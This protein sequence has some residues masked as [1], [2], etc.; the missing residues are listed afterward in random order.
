M[1]DVRNEVRKPDER[2]TLVGAGCRRHVPH[3]AAPGRFERLRGLPIASGA[4]LM[5][6]VLACALA[7]VL[8]NCDPKAFYYDALNVPPNAEHYFGT[9]ALGRDLFSIMLYG[10]R[11]SLGIGVLAAAI[12]AAIGIIYGSVSGTAGDRIDSAMMRLAELLGSIPSLLIVLILTAI[13]PAKNVFSMSAVIGVTGWLGLAR[14]VRSEVRQ[15]RNTEYVLYARATGGRF[16]Y[17]MRRHLVPNFLSAVM[18]VVVSGVSSAIAMESTLSFLGLGLPVNE[19]SW[20]SILSLANRALITNSW[21][22]IVIPGLFLV[23]TLLC[24]TDIGNRLR[25]ATD[26]R[27]SFL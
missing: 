2:F 14:L 12:M 8:S 17:V 22:L 13:F 18:F 25:K 26:R 10:G 27:C 16:L 21:W 15:I 23:V 1:V 4:V 7:P 9:D 20:G 5:L 11:A 3:I 24:I 19:L 6:I